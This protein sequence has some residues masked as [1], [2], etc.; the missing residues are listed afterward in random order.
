MMFAKRF[1]KS[2]STLGVKSILWICFFAI[3]AHVESLAYFD[4]DTRQKMVKEKSIWETCF[5][6]FAIKSWSFFI[7][8]RFDS[9]LSFKI[10]LD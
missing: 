3:L 10:A 5:Q 4:D 9:K 7:K 2:S 8:F 6:H 1:F